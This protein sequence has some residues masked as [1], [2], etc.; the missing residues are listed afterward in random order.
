MSNRGFACQFCWVNLIER[1]KQLAIRILQ[2]LYLKHMEL[3]SYLQSFLD[4]MFYFGNSIR[5]LASYSHSLL[6]NVLI[7]DVADELGL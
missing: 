7:V 5:E 2:S 4:L 6:F 1:I 3:T